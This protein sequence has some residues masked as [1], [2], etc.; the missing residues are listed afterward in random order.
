MNFVWTQT[1]EN[2]P[3]LL[4]FLYN[5]YKNSIPTTRN[6]HLDF[7]FTKVTNAPLQRNMHW[8]FPLIPITNEPLLLVMRISYR[9]RLQM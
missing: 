7:I 9:H 2:Y 5:V 4:N 6:L 3:I 1:C 8:A